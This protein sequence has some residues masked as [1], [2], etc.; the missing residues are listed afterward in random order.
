MQNRNAEKKNKNMK[1]LGLREELFDC[2]IGGSNLKED[3]PEGAWKIK[4]CGAKDGP[5]ATLLAGTESG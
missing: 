4:P 2:R 1:N 3:K 5:S